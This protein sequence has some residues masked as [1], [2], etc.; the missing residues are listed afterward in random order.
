MH[1]QEGLALSQVGRDSVG[2]AYW[3][4]S[5]TPRQPRACI[6]AC[7]ERWSNSDVCRWVGNFTG[8]LRVQ[9]W[10]YLPKI[11]PH[12]ESSPFSFYS[13]NDV[14]GV[15][16]RSLVPVLKGTA[17]LEGVAASCDCC[18]PCLSHPLSLAGCGWPSRSACCF[19]SAAGQGSADK[20]AFCGAVSTFLF[21]LKTNKDVM[22]KVFHCIFP[23]LI[24]CHA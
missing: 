11:I 24:K 6:Q 9:F 15:R 1:F 8:I 18:F 21:I 22:D 2:D 23:W 7:A 14:A 5:G 10:E 12:P 16:W 17:Q 13:A 20:H 19:P 3:S 4:P